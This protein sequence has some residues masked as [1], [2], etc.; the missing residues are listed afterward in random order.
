[1]PT[2]DLS[3]LFEDWTLARP[4]QLA[5]VP[6]VVDMLYQ[7]YQT[8]LDRLLGE[9]HSVAAA[10]E[11]A[12]AELREHVLGGRVLGGIVATAP[13]SGEMRRFLQSCVQ[14]HVIDGYGLTEIGGVSRDGVIIR[15][16][17][18]D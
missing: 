12:K 10:D 7:R 13:L 3:T 8:H 18:I 9:G 15:P 16:P 2:S 5:V 11:T 6:R 4:T 17:V 14:A 1:M